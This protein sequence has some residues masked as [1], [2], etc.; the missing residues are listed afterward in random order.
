MNIVSLNDVNRIEVDQFI[1]DEWDGP[2]I[3]TLGNL[4]DSSVLPGYAA[5]E[6]EKII[7]AVLYRIVGDECEIAALYSLSQNRGVGTALINKVIEVVR[8]HGCRRIWLVTTNDNTHAIRFYQKFGFNLKAVYI[9]SFEVI[10]RLKK[11]LPTKGIDGIPLEHEFE[12]EIML[13]A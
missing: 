10:R 8:K 4:Y 2:M 13:E 7:G 5:L 11:G 9:G 6:N 1:K 3:V 12:F